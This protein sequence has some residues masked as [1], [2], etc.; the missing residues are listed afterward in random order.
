MKASGLL[1]L[2]FLA[3]C[4]PPPLPVLAG[5]PLPAGTARGIDMPTDARDVAME[6]GGSHLDFVARYYRDPASRWPA[7]SADEARTV[8]A[9]G[10]KLV[11][12][13]ESH[14]HNP[15][16]FSY[17]SGYADALSAYRQAKAVGQPHGSAI[18]FAV[19]FNAQQGDIL[20][21]VDAYFRGVYNGL[22]EAAGGHVPDYRVGVYGSGAVCSYLKQARL[23]AYTWLS[24]STAWAGYNRFTD[25]NIRQ[26]GQSL[27]LSFSQDSNEARGDYG[28][29]SI[30]GGSSPD[31]LSAEAQ[32][33][34]SAPTPKPISLN[35]T[36]DAL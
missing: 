23:A 12:I 10:K 14:S 1:T 3:G 36:P 33:A 20:G 13:W 15:A 26:G 2:L 8:S 7:L 32:R 28:G 25:W 29:F 22:I 11:A 31:N 4:S 6:L 21:P 30:P 27:L 5:A 35:G 34:R 18:Y 17:G 9:T 24:N 19:D 16:Y